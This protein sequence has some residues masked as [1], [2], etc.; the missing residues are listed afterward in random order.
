MIFVWST[1]WTFHMISSIFS[2]LTL[3]LLRTNFC[4][5]CFGIPVIF[6]SLIFVVL[7]PSQ[8][9]F[10]FIEFLQVPLTTFWVSL[11]FK[12]SILLFTVAYF[13]LILLQ[14]SIFFLNIKYLCDSKFSSVALV[15]PSTLFKFSFFCFSARRDRSSYQTKTFSFPHYFCK[16]CLGSF[17]AD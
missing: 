10:T 4:R 13:F 1:F 15:F 2:W 11:H 8:A 14:S 12:C 16:F 17:R 3:S 6:I 9:Q 7:L 5:S